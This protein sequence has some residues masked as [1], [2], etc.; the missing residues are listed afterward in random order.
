[1]NDNSVKQVIEG[2]E[3]N[4]RWR[5]SEEGKGEWIWLMYFLYK[6]EYGTLKHVEVTLRRGVEQEGEKNQTRV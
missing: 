3:M 2:E 6:C 5:V 4:R 1:M